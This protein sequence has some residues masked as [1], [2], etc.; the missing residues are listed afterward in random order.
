MARSHFVK[1]AQKNIY[2]NGK[3]VEY[4]SKK[5]KRAGQTLTKHDRTVPENKKDTI[6]IAK[7]E[8]YYWWQFKNGPK[9]YS[10]SAPKSSQLTQSGYLSAIYDLQDEL[11]ELR[12]NVSEAEDLQEKVEDIKSRMEELR[13]E[14]EEKKNNM[15]EGLQEGPTGELLQERYDSLDS[16]ISELEGIDLDDYDEADD[17]DIREELKDD[18]D[19]T[20]DED[21]ARKALVSDEM[22]ED[23]KSEKLSEWLDEKC[24]EIS[25]ISFE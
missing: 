21:A 8:S 4:K 16:A 9:H 24:E 25:Q 13:D 14:Q 15:P 17:D 23:Y 10:K 11:S 1:K 12:G 22:I 5:G 20:W 6:L 2:V 19:D 3:Y 18:I 7:G